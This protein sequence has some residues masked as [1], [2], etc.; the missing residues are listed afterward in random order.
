VPAAQAYVREH[1]AP[2]AA[3]PA[4][5]G[6][7]KRDGSATGRSV[8]RITEALASASD[9]KDMATLGHNLA[10]AQAALETAEESWLEWPSTTKAGSDS[11]RR[12]RT[13]RLRA[14][15]FF[16]GPSKRPS[17]RVA[18]SWA[19]ARQQLCLRCPDSP[20]TRR[21]GPD[22]E[23]AGGPCS[24]RS[25]TRGQLIM[26]GGLPHPLPL[27]HETVIAPFAVHELTTVQMDAA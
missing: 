21:G 8:T 1:A 24:G 2:L 26:F 16:L 5:P 13:W 11:I 9:Y 17:S 6:H 18:P 25:R 12:P 27:E 20:G 14:T 4:P 3:G 19:P 10:D 15:N 22:T 7:R 23:N